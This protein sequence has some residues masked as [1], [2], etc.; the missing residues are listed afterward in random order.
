[1]KD[2]EAQLIWEALQRKDVVKEYDK[3]TCEHCGGT[4]SHLV[5]GEGDAKDYEETC[6]K[7][8]GSGDAPVD[9][10]DSNQEP[11]DRVGDEATGDPSTFQVGQILRSQQTGDHLDGM[12]IDISEEDG[13][14][15]FDL[16]EIGEEGWTVRAKDIKPGDRPR[17]NF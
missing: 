15:T 3:P 8:G 11:V 9:E 2:K 13:E 6:E 12:I 10:T 5:Q 1:M 17:T 14:L 4:G 16:M 7:C